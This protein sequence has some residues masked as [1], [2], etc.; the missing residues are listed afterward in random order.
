[1]SDLLENSENQILLAARL[2]REH[3]YPKRKQD[4]PDWIL[5]FAI[6]DLLKTNPDTPPEDL[7]DLL[8][9]QCKLKA[10]GLLSRYVGASIAARLTRKMDSAAASVF[11]GGRKF[12]FA[13]VSAMAEY[14]TSRCPRICRAKLSKLLFYSDFINY[15]LNGNSISG[16]RYVRDRFG[17]ELYGY[18]TL[19]KTLLY[20]GSLRVG[21]G[22]DHEEALL[23][24]NNWMIDTLTIDE[25]VTM[26]WVLSY[27]RSMTASEIRQYSQKEIAYR[28]TRRDA[29]IAYE[30]A[31]ILHG[32]PDS[33]RKNYAKLIY[34]DP[35]RYQ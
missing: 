34:G 7:F 35:R 31:S 23:V 12:S 32:L 5:I 27:F 25:V 19:F 17:P 20:T 3:H 6:K 10:D 29:F 2:V 18:E 24:N 21:N 13:K 14:L 11:T 4:L 8:I 1:M 15:Y 26:H 30:Y 16:A 22:S 33:T 28:F 9:T